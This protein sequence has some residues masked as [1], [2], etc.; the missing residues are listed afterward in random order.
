M[1]TSPVIKDIISCKA[2][3]FLDKIYEIKEEQNKS[4]IIIDTTGV[5]VKFLK[6]KGAIIDVSELLLNEKL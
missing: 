5:I 4:V 6:Y 3:E 2:D 1:N